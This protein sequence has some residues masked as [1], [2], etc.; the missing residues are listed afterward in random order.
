MLIKFNFE[1]TFLMSQVQNM[2]YVISRN[3]TVNTMN[4]LTYLRLE[5]GS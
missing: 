4:M 5:F 2:F 1:L 3:I